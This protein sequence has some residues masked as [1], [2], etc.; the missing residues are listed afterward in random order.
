MTE[1]QTPKQKHCSKLWNGLVIRHNGYVFPCC[2]LGNRPELAIGNINEQSF[3]EIVNGTRVQEMRRQSLDGVLPCYESCDQVKYFTP[4][5]LQRPTDILTNPALYADLQIEYGELCNVDCVMCWQDRSNRTML[6]FETLKERLPLGSWKIVNAYGGEV[7]VMKSAMQHID[8]MMENRVPIMITTNGKALTNPELAKK[9]VGGC[10]ALIVSMNAVT[11]ETHTKVMRP[12][13]P[14]F[15]QVLEN[16]KTLNRLRQE[17]NSRIWITGHFTV[18]KESLHEFP[19]FIETFHEL[20]FDEATIGF[21]HR[22]FPHYLKENPDVL[23]E[24]RPRV[25]AAMEKAK[26]RKVTLTSHELFM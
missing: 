17:M 15:H 9:V 10:R 22:Y 7:F 26:G 1:P 11:E 3:E 18:V 6:D 21:D 16:V 13:K 25:Q 12:Q 19:T 5:E 8:L 24:I 20:G 4:F 23:E 14:F 2:Q